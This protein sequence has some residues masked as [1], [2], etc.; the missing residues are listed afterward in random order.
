MFEINHSS[1]ML[2][3]S[4]DNLPAII[5]ARMALELGLVTIA[6]EKITD[7]ALARPQKKCFVAI[8]NA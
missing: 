3:L 5:E 7:K 6:V 2:D 1:V 4:I 8:L